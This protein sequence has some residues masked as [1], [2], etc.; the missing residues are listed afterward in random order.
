MQL[1]S[2]HDFDSH[3]AV[4]LECCFA[5]SGILE[6]R[7]GRR[8]RIGERLFELALD[9][10]QMIGNFALASIFFID[11]MLF[12]SSSNHGSDNSFPRRLSDGRWLRLAER[13]HPLDRE[14]NH[15]NGRRIE[16]LKTDIAKGIGNRDT[17]IRQLE[18][19]LAM[20]A[21]HVRSAYGHWNESD[22]ELE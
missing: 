18:S 5:I 12:R 20:N 19:E 21:R 6:R 15:Q 22:V 8:W 7:G 11:H 4:C 2:K 16:L 9:L 14:A 10:V 13:C 1:N 17:K 3:P